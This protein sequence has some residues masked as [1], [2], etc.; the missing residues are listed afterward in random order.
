MIGGRKRTPMPIRDI[1]LRSTG[2]GPVVTYY[3]TKEELEKMREKDGPGCGLTKRGLIEA[4]A[5]GESLSSI[6]RAWSM[7]Y[8]TIHNWTKKWGLKG[9]TSDKAQAMLDEQP[10]TVEAENI[11]QE[12]P[13]KIADDLEEAPAAPHEADKQT[14]I[15]PTAIAEPVDPPCG[16]EDLK[17]ARWYIDRLIG[18][19]DQESAQTAAIQSVVQERKRQD[20]KWGEQNHDPIVWIG[21]L[22]EEF[23]ELSQAIIETHFDNGPEERR[24]H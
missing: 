21:I 6:E 4:I 2:C 14:V 7:K 22:G 3:L 15:I 1:E 20:G 18:E 16:V 5:A 11:Q 23:G 13:E 10:V 19:L 8:N 17:K 12:Q 9:L 24:R